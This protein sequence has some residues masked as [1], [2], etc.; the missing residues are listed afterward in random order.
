M[1]N[2]VLMWFLVILVRCDGLNFVRLFLK[3]NDCVLLCLSVFVSVR[4]ECFNDIWVCFIVICVV[5]SMVFVCVCMLLF[6]RLSVICCVLFVKFMVMGLV[7]F[8]FFSDVCSVCRL[9]W[10][11]F[12]WSVLCF[13]CILVLFVSIVLFSSCMLRLVSC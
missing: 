10:C 7:S 8:V 11:I 5:L 3:V 12:M 4:C 6:V 2:L 1:L 9:S 13:F